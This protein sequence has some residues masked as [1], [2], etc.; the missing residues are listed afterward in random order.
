MVPWERAYI[1][2]D[3]PGGTS[4]LLQ[5]GIQRFG[6]VQAVIHEAN[7]EVVWHPCNAPPPSMIM[8]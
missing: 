8:V 1:N 6:L 3:K 4:R 5:H 2:V 7:Q